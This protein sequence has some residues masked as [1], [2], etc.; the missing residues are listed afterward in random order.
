MNK[1]TTNIF[2]FAT[3]AILSLSTTNT[4]AQTDLPVGFSKEEIELMKSPDW[5]A[6]NYADEKSITTPPSG[7]LR[8]M[9]QWEEVKEV[10]I[11]WTSYTSV[12]KEI[13]RSVAP[14]TKVLIVC[15]G[16]SSN[17]STSIK[18]YLSATQ[19]INSVTY[20]PVPT[21]TIANV[22]FIYAPYNSVWMRD[23]GPNAVYV[24]D[25]D[26]LVLV[27]WKYNRPTRPKD[28]TV[29]RSVGR[30]L[31]LKVYETSAAG[32][33]YLVNTGGNWMSDGLGTSFHS[34][35]IEQDNPALTVPQIDT[36]LSHYHGITRSIK[37]P[38]L[39]FD[40]IHHIDMHIKLLNEETLL[41][42]EYPTGTADG[43]QIEANLQ[44]ILSNFNSVFGTPYKVV[45]IPQ[46][47][48]PVN[49]YTYPDNGGYYL[50]YTNA[51]IV[52]KT[53][54]VPQYY[55]F[56]SY[57]STALR[58]WRGAMPGYN[59]VGI[60]SSSTISASGSLHCITHEIGPNDPLLI[61]HQ[62]LPN[63]T[64]TTVPYQ[65][66]A[67]IQHRTGIQYATLYYTNDTTLGFANIPMTLTNATLNTW[68]GFIPAYPSGTNVFYYIKAHAN[69]GKEQLRPM[70]APHG[71]FN[72]WV[73]GT[74]GISTN[75]AVISFMKDAYPNPSHGITCIPVSIAKNTKGSIKLYDILGNIVEV[76]YEGEMNAG[77]K[78]YFI[79]STN[80]AAG[81]YFIA[82]E[83]PEVK[84][85]QKLMVR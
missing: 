14:E 60:N 59:V 39:P 28:D 13:V 23:Y 11:T 1:I 84:L 76:I 75:E 4:K 21:N 68:T 43:P 49:G 54:I 27:D 78:N 8:S 85:T 26:S 62:N 66:D 56:V 30:K 18:N 37:M 2:L 51:T 50:T 20:P 67:R 5:Q 9:A 40:G 74:T 61:V 77:D 22:G 36:I 24:N 47:P 80:I 73:Q 16:V 35:L 7:P 33:N 83:T 71:D 46:P 41:V 63:T 79:N 82:V 53:V 69:S 81:A 48:D 55:N 58:I 72:F 6:P 3:T 29:P 45:R 25:V 65:V 17:D 52:N 42:G 70:P 12:L 15:T 64:N 31:N 57:D 32:V 10:L 44:Y 34:E 38:V 19:V